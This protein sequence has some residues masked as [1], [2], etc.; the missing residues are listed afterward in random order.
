M[1]YAKVL[2]PIALLLITFSCDLIDELF[3]SDDP[4]GSGTIIG[5]WLESDAAISLSITTNSAQTA[6]NFLN[7]TGELA[8]TGD[9]KTKLPLMVELVDEEEAENSTLIVTNTSGFL[10]YTDTTYL[11]MFD[12]SGN[13]NDAFMLV[14]DTTD[15]SVQLE[16]D[17]ASYSY[18]GTTLNVNNSTL[19]DDDTQTS[20]TI[21]GSIASQQ[22][23][24]PANTATTL[25]FNSSQYYEFGSTVT[26]FNEDSTFISSED[27]G[28]GDDTG[29][30]LIVGDTLKITTTQA[31]EDPTTGETTYIDT[32]WAF[33]YVNTGNQVI[34]SQTIAICDLAD[35]S[36]DEE[37]MTCEEIYNTI[38]LFFGLDQNSI[39]DGQLIYQLFFDRITDQQESL[40][41]ASTTDGSQPWSPENIIYFMKNSRN[42]IILNK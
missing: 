4:S 38:E 15:F 11:L 12:P 41:I 23:N 35:E 37:A 31:V 20:A 10:G 21:N 22:V 28:L 18:D 6:N 16:T 19:Q 17:Q 2:L 34:L 13:S 30:W 14:S 5:E 33:N 36:G 7:S 3:E 24:I 42:R 8:V 25:S 29:T 26:T 39:T 32:T 9:F 1:K 40:N 27:T